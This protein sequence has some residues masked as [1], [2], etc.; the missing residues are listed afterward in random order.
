MKK[1]Y[2]LLFTFLITSLSFGQVINEVDA[3]TPGTDAAEF[4][5]I[6][7]TPNTPLDN[8]TVVFFNG[9]ND[10]SYQVFDLDTYTTDANG[11]FILANSALAD[12]PGGD[13]DIGTSNVLQNGADAVALY[14][15]DFTPGLITANNLLGGVVYDTSDNDDTGLLAVIGGVQY[16]EAENGAKD[17]QSVQRNSD[18]TYTVK[19]TTFRSS[20]DA[21][22]C[23][24]SLSNETAT[25]DNI[26][27]GQDTYTA[28]VDFTGGGTSTYTVTSDVGTVDLSSGNP[29]SDATGTITVNNVPEGT[30]VTITV[31]D[32]GLCDLNSI[33]TAVDC[34]PPLTLPLS[35]DF[36]YADGPLTGNPNWSEYSG[37]ALQ[38]AVVSGE[39]IVSEDGSLSEDV[40]IAFIANSGGDIFYSLD[41]KVNDPG[42]PVTGGDYEYFACFKND[43]FGLSGRIDIIEAT[44]GGD[45]TIG[46]STITSAANVEW[47]SALNYGTTYR[48]AVRYN[49]DDNISELWIDASSQTDTSIISNDE[50]DPGLTISEF[51]LRQSNSSTDETIIVDNLLVA[52]TFNDVLSNDSLGFVDSFKLYP[53]PTNTGYVNITSTNGGTI[54]AKVFDILGKKVIDASIENNRLDVNQLKT[55]IYIIKMTQGTSSITKKL[56]IE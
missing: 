6:L 27:S 19:N 30:D 46:L 28:T 16:N 45:F 43:S 32:G 54:N 48:V 55:G 20:N 49:Q 1:L 5:E 3:D 40:S 12:V 31:Q 41:F 13:I 26:T 18:G 9:T 14:S 35:E 34:I 38:L 51:A 4:V 42:G 10:S 22:V 17:S 11:F 8:L 53:N 44:G 15:G 21:A 39:A 2:F 7:W 37:T 47:G 24:L 50:A 56:V 25:C 52:S 23:D 36:T 29:T 33:V